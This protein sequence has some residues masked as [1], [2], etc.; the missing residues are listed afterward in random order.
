MAAAEFSNTLRQRSRMPRPSAAVAAGVLAL[1]SHS[2]GAAGSA[3]VELWR[4]DCG[5]FVDLRLDSMSDVYAYPDQKKKTLTNSCYLIRHNDDYMLWD[6]GF[7]PSELKAEASG[8]GAKRET[9]VQQLARIAVPPEKVTLIGISHF[10]SDHTG[11]AS[12]F[13]AARLLIGRPDFELLANGA[14]SGKPNDIQQWLAHTAKVDQV[15]GDK[16]VFGDGTVVM[17]ATPG[18]TMG[19]YS[20]LVRLAKRGNVILS[21]DLWHF[22]A[23][24]PHDGMPAGMPAGTTMSR[25]EA[26]ASMDRIRRATANLDAVLIIQHEPVDIEKLPMFPLSAR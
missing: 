2:E 26:L 18:H 3:E 12:S 9:L 5:E 15:V 19:H 11:Q 6:T 10:H 22:A 14:R 25:A 16:D 13:P 21:G 23:Q 7:R 24:I 20:L 4:L 1:L 8:N 17:L